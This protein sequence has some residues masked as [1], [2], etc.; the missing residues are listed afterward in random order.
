MGTGQLLTV[1]R[2]SLC[3]SATIDLSLLTSSRDS[4]MTLTSRV[5]AAATFRTT[6]T[7]SKESTT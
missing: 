4:R 6:A 3:S 7:D 1:P 2:L 5:L